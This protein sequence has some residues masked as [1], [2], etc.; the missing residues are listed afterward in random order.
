MNQVYVRYYGAYSVRRRA[1]WRRD[2][3]LAE[4]RAPADQAPPDHTPTSAQIRARRC[5][6]AEL[7][8]RIFEVEPLRCPRC[9]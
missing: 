8:Q 3:I 7:L 6:W 5:R 4:T 1:R 9:G 2:G